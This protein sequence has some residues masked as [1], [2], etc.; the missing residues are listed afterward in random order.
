MNVSKLVRRPMSG[1]LMQMEPCKSIAHWEIV[2]CGRRASVQI[3]H[4]FDVNEN[5]TPRPG[6][7]CHKHF[8]RLQA[9]WAVIDV[10]Q[11]PA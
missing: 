8:A 2:N 10:R 4:Y 5:E 9:E 3:R 6:R 7:L 11:N 1:V